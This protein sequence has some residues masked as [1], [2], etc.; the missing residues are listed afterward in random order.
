MKAIIMIQTSVLINLCLIDIFSNYAFFPYILITI[1]SI[2]LAMSQ[3]TETKMEKEIGSV[4]WY[5]V[6]RLPKKNHDAMVVVQTRHVVNIIHSVFS[7]Y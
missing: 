7:S 2:V 6:A 4:V 5:S 3:S 1:F